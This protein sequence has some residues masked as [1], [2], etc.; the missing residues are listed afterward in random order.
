MKIVS[1]SI[2]KA[3][4]EA[5]YPQ[6]ITFY[7]YVTQDYSTFK[8]GELIDSFFA[9]SAGNNVVD[10]PTVMEVWLWLWREN[11]ARIVIGSD[12][13][14]IWCS[15]NNYKP[16]IRATKDPEETIEKAINYLAENNL[17]K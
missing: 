17:I 3:I 2:A 15:K 5:G 8:E 6:D 12:T 13:C 11:I 9:V 4:K 14:Y 16:I 1:Y 10:A 7:M